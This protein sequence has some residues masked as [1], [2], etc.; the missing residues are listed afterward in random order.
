MERSY[1]ES[2][3]A[4]LGEDDFACAVAALIA[5]AALQLEGAG[6]EA[7]IRERSGPHAEP[8]AVGNVPFSF[9][10]RAEELRDLWKRA[11][12]YGGRTGPRFE[13]P[14]DEPYLR[15]LLSRRA[16]GATSVYVRN[17][18]SHPGVVLDWPLRIGVLPDAR[19]EEAQAIVAAS[20][21]PQ[22]L[23]P[24][25][26]GGAFTEC[27]ILLMPSGLRT[28]A[29]A[30]L[31]HRDPLHAD[32][33]LITGLAD[34]TPDEGSALMGLIR[35]HTSAAAIAIAGVGRD[36]RERWMNRVIETLAHDQPLDAALFA[37]ADV[38]PVLFAS[39]ALLEASRISTRID[40]LAERIEQTPGTIVQT[41]D[42]PVY[43]VNAEGEVVHLDDVLRADR[44]Y[45]YEVSPYSMRGGP[46][47]VPTPSADL[48]TELRDRT[49]NFGAESGAASEYVAFKK[50]LPAALR[51]PRRAAPPVPAAP[52][53]EVLATTY[54]DAANVANG[55]LRDK[56]YSVEIRVGFRAAGDVSGGRFREE[57]IPPGGHLVRV[58][59]CELP[60][61]EQDEVRQPQT[62]GIV[63]P[64]GGESERARFYFHTSADA[65]RF[66]ARV[67]LVY[68]NRVLHTNRYA[69]TLGKD[70]VITFDPELEVADLALLDEYE[71]FEGALVVNKAGGRMGVLTVADEAVR[72]VAPLGL[73]G[74]VL[75]LSA[76]LSGIAD[77]EK[78]PKVMADPFMAGLLFKLANRGHVLWETLNLTENAPQLAKA[79]RIH[80]VAAR[81]GELLPVELLYPRPAPQKQVFCTHAAEAMKAGDFKARCTSKDP[82]V[83]LC[84][85]EFWALNR[86]IEHVS[87]LDKPKKAAGAPL[88]LFRKALLGVS[89]NVLK[90]DADKVARTLETLTGT[91]PLLVTSLQE[92][93]DAVH[94]EEPSLLVLLPHSEAHHPDT[95]LPALEI[96]GDELISR[97]WIGPEHVVKPGVA[98]PV[99]LLLGC[100]TTL[101]DLPFQNFAEAIKKNGAAVVLGTLSVVLGRHAA[102]FAVALLE[103]LHASAGKGLKFG[104]VLLDVKRRRL[105]AG[106]PF[107]LS[108]LAYGDVSIRI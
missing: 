8:I 95:G 106:D 69:A 101:T 11:V 16:V 59:F 67:L 44:N 92:W 56:T 7:A 24:V 65:D 82:R 93:Q 10:D 61:G 96:G 91:K 99:V 85:L 103:A 15:E 1:F 39:R 83:E 41:V 78:L 80:V 75:A 88:Q 13:L 94:D 66:E 90:K 84:P 31:Q 42:M 100:T 37:A 104:D 20:Y 64:N 32:C 102:P 46:T 26:L 19:A 105:A 74:E 9:R 77:Q 107:A 48:A 5:R 87:F 68:E 6:L 81:S 86:V 52:A 40:L 71:R 73:D 17:E 43:A 53:R 57:L 62:Q 12:P 108:L 76:L 70:S 72:Y 49:R 47:D 60:Q 4:S 51:A 14:E 30:L 38:P 23:E 25:R 21:W 55:L 28:A 79:S 18:R 36:E 33:V 34:A 63:L 3:G 89:K 58:I 54:D 97:S 22:L 35:L 2:F 27:D 50:R 29:A 98:P 45:R